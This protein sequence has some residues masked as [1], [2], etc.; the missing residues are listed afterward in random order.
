MMP[1]FG[2]SGVV[3]AILTLL[4]WILV[5]LMALFYFRLLMKGAGSAGLRWGLQTREG[6]APSQSM[7]RTMF[8][9]HG[10]TAGRK[11]TPV[12]SADPPTLDMPGQGR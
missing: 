6:V 9:Q 11:V 8:Y 7:E 3:S 12:T 1:S 4:S 5:L 10:R 2:S